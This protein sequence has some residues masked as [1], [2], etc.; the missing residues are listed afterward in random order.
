[1][2]YELT[3]RG[4]TAHIKIPSLD[5]HSPQNS[6]IVDGFDVLGADFVPINPTPVPAI[7]EQPAVRL[8]GGGI[9]TRECS[10]SQKSMK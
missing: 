2:G 10:A 7:T 4:D 1:M 3:Q 8:V 5:L 6:P 9:R